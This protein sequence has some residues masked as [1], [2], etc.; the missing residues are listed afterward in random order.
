MIAQ[1]PD[2][3]VSG[4]AG[5]KTLGVNLSIYFYL[6]IYLSY[7]H[8]TMYVW[9]S[10]KVSNPWG[11]PQLSSILW[12]IIPAI[13]PPPFLG[14]P[15]KGTPHRLLLQAPLSNANLGGDDPQTRANNVGLASGCWT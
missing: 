5:E 6:L 13:N 9:N 7:I 14:I 11:H 2:D 10:M 8:E 15:Q 1:I 4:C 12:G 3:R